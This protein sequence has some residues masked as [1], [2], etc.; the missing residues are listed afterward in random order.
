MASGLE[1]RVD[2]GGV[3]ARLAAYPAQQGQALMRAVN[4]TAEW[5]RTRT[6]EAVVGNLAVKKSDLD[7]SHDFGG[8]KARKTNQPG[9]VAYV[10]I[11]GNRIPLFLFKGKPTAAPSKRG[12]SY[13]IDAGGGRKSITKNAFYARMKSGHAGLFTRLSNLQQLRRYHLLGGAKNLRIPKA[14]LRARTQ[15]RELFGPSIPHVAENRPEFK[16]MLEVD[17][18]ARLEMQV[19]REVNFILTGTSKGASDGN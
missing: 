9:G 4:R 14:G 16:K 7:G 5:C 18:G 3:I 17:A 11:T 13:Q 10:N 19:G 2:D 12:I 6:V 1:I 15:I 8:I